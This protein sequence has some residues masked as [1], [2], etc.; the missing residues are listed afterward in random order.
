MPAPSPR[1]RDVHQAPQRSQLKYPVLVRHQGT[2]IALA[3]DAD[4]AQRICG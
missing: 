2:V 1:F 4:G 3:M